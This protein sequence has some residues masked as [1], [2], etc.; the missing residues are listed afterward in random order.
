MKS[1][2]SELFKQQTQSW[3]HR[4]STDVDNDLGVGYFTFKAKPKDRNYCKKLQFWLA[5]PKTRAVANAAKSFLGY[6]PYSN[7][8]WFYNFA[9][10]LNTTPSFWKVITCL[11][12]K[13][14]FSAH[15]L[16][17]Y[18]WV[19]QC[20]AKPDFKDEITNSLLRSCKT[21]IRQFLKTILWPHGRRQDFQSPRAGRG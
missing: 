13:S 5:W 4:R 2:S 11:S 15:S 19:K 21:H 18:V 17:W 16:L 10:L 1:A 6:P 20:L 7:S 3:E 8:K 12:C 9:V 14:L